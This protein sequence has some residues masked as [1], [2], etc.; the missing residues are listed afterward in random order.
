MATENRGPGFLS[1]LLLGGLIGVILGLL[2]APQPGEK[3]RE[4]LQ[5]RLDE[6]TSLGKSAWEEGKEAASQ[7][8]A[9][10]RARFE[11]ATG[12]HD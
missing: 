3:T 10:L 9:E 1:G 6:L 4:Q 2:Y 5:G 11:Q 7:R 12:R 8:S